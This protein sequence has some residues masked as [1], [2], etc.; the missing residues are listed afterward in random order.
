MSNNAKI[1][2]S[3]IESMVYR[4]KQNNAKQSTINAFKN[5]SQKIIKSNY[6]IT[7]RLKQLRD[8][9]GS[10][11]TIKTSKQLVRDNAIHNKYSKHVSRFQS[12]VDAKPTLAKVVKALSKFKKVTFKNLP[13][14]NKTKNVLQFRINKQQS[15]KQIEQLGNRLSKL[16]HKDKVHGAMSIA[17]RYDKGWRAGYFTNFGEDIKLYN[18]DMYDNEHEH[19]VDHQDTFKQFVIYLTETPQAR[20]G[21]DSDNNDCVYKALYHVLFDS[22]PWK[23]ALAFKRAL[24][25]KYNDKLDLYKHI[26]MIEK[27]LKNIAINVTGDYVYTST[28]KSNKVINLKIINEHCTLDVPKSHKKITKVSYEERKPII[29]DTISFMAYDGKKEYKMSKEERSKHFDFE[30][31]YIL[32]V[33][34]DNKLTLKEEY[35]E[36]IKDADMIK[37]ET[38]GYINLYKTG[39]KDKSIALDLFDRYTKHIANPPE[40][41]QA[42]AGFINPSSQGAIIFA[43]DYEGPAYKYDIVSMYPSLMNSSQCFPIGEGTFMKLEQAEFQEMINKGFFTFGIYKVNII[44]NHLKNKLFRFNKSNYYTHIDL[45]RAL[46]LNLDMKLNIDDQPNFLHY[47]RDKLL[48]GKELFKNY[49]EFLYPLKA[50]KIPRMKDT[51]NILWGALSQRK[52]VKSVV[53]DDDELYKIPDDCT[54]DSIKPSFDDGYTHIE[55]YHNEHQYKSGFARL[56]PFL[57]AKG[58]ATISKIMEPYINDIVRCHTDGF[59]SKEN[60][61]IKTGWNIGEVRYEG[62]NKHYYK[63]QK[64]YNKDDFII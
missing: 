6:K 12:F 15:K 55:V 9:I 40:I 31:D 52:Y 48:S 45:T 25:L 29:Y 56:K 17:L 43:D 54:L 5:E 3:L 24:G 64:S 28:V 44:Y 26:P 39:Y 13:I 14:E 32:V 41:K 47:P 11:P 1:H 62:F 8:T 35:D 63:T 19:Y 58:R 59:I 27:T 46:E 2:D 20:M 37:K 7:T 42:E 23:S 53:K 10:N 50:N 36:F 30:T 34:R 61:S 49:V 38:N 57:L 51:L 4:L 22:M 21:Y 33:K 16:F 18:P 60:L